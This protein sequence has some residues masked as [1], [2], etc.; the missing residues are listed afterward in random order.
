MDETPIRT[1]EL[2]RS[3]HDQ[4]YEETR[5]MTSEEFTAFVTR[6]AG[7]ALQQSGRP[8]EARPAA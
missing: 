2:V 3:I 5:E 1:A 6:E 4:L 7:K 8:S